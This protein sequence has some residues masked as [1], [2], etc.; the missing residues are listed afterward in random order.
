[1][2]SLS[3]RSTSLKNCLR[4]SV[5]VLALADGFAALIG[6]WYQG[7]RYNIFGGYKTYI[8]SYTFF[9]IT[10]TL[11]LNFMVISSQVTM[12]HLLIVSLGAVAV[13]ATEALIAGGFDNIAIPVASVAV[14]SLL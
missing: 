12:E 4:L 13:T 14:L 11:F 7:K 9:V 3:I 2:I 5:L 6:K 10:L 1:M 8:G